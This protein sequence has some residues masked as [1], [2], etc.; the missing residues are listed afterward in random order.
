MAVLAPNCSLSKISHYQLR[1]QIGE[2]G[3]G[4][5]YRGYDEVTGDMVAIKV[6]P[7]HLLANP[8]FLKRFEQEYNVARQLNHPNIVKALDFGFEGSH[9]Y[10]VMELVEGESVGDY[11]ERH[12]KFDEGEAVRIITQV[13][14]ALRVAHKQGLVHRDVKPDNILLTQNHQ[15]KLTD[16]GLVKET[17]TNHGL[18]RTG[19]GLGTPNFM[20]PEQFRNAKNANPLCDIYS[21]GA[22]LYMML[23]G[24]LPFESDG[25]VD[26]FM[27]KVNNQLVSVRSL[28]PAVSERIETTIR[29]AINADPFRRHQSCQEL[30]DDLLGATTRRIDSGTVVDSSPDRWFLYYYDREGILH[31]LKG[32]LDGVRRSIKNGEFGDPERVRIARTKNGPFESLRRY[33]EFRDL[34]ALPNVVTVGSECQEFTSTCSMKAVEVPESRLPRSPKATSIGTPATVSSNGTVGPKIAL[35][36]PLAVEEAW[37]WSF[38]FLVSVVAGIFAYFLVLRL[39]W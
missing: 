24:R 17:E 3:M 19:R 2:G 14:E 28:N 35:P 6:V 12:G 29:R 30:I 26:A 34:L 27:K 32:S 36:S 8:V 39:N 16:L 4:T 18:T 15:A 22:T 13:A 37:K 38:F 11:L 23:T 1:D 9:H 31:T 7:A 10:L 25:P 20:A 21:M 33:G 5:V